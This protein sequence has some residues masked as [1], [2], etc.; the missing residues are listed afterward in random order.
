MVAMFGSNAGPGI[1]DRN[2]A[3]DGEKPH[4]P[5][6]GIALMSQGPDNHSK[7]YQGIGVAVEH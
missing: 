2:G 6:R 1:A 3:D 5:N 4:Q 7:Y